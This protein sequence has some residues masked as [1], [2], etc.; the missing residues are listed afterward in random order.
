M[1][2]PLT[3]DFVKRIRTLKSILDEVYP[4]SFDDWVHGFELDVN[5]EKELL[6]WECM[7]LTYST[8]M[9]GRSLSLEAK[10]E[11]INVILQASLGRTDEYILNSKRKILPYGAVQNLL[12]LYQVSAEAT[13]AVNQLRQNPNH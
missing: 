5:P 13:F 10:T 1:S 3:S 4:K 7:A 12:D 11:A 6:I 9:E 8:F 2:S